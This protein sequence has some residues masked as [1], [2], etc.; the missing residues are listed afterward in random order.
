[1]VADVTA[2]PLKKIVVGSFK[3][4]YR[5]TFPELEDTTAYLYFDIL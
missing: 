1:M 5:P 3:S 4:N 2:C